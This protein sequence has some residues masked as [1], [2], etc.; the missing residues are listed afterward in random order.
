[1]TPRKTIRTMRD[2]IE[3]L[4]TMPMDGAMAQKLIERAVATVYVGTRGDDAR[5]VVDAFKTHLRAFPNPAHEL[6][7]FYGD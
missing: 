4:S 5:C 2:L 1:M 6:P 7:L 3:Y